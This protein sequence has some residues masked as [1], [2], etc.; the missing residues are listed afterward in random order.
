MRRLLLSLQPTLLRHL[1]HK[2]PMQLAAC[3][4]NEAVCDTNSA[5]VCALVPN[6]TTV[7]TVGWDLLR[8]VCNASLAR[9]GCV[10][11][12]VKIRYERLAVACRNSIASVVCGC[13]GMRQPAVVPGMV[14]VL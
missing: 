14:G 8:V 10:W 4:A 9:G 13:I 7:M 5:S 1:H 12:D 2:Q 11:Y 6:G 3:V